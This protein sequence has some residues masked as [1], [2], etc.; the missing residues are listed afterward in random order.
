MFPSTSFAQ[1]PN[2]RRSGRFT[3]APTRHPE[4]QPKIK[5][6][7][8]LQRSVSFELPP[9]NPRQPSSVS[10][11]RSPSRSP[12]RSPHSRRTPPRSPIHVNFSP[13]QPIPPFARLSLDGMPRSQSASRS[14]TSHSSTPRTAA[15]PSTNTFTTRTHPPP[16][17]VFGNPPTPPSAIVLDHT[18][19]YNPSMPTY[20]QAHTHTVSAMPHPHTQPSA[21]PLFPPPAP[22]VHYPTTTTPP[23]HYRTINVRSIEDQVPYF[24]GNVRNQP[25]CEG[26][27]NIPL[28]LWLNALDCLF[29][30]EHITD[31]RQRIHYLIHFCDKKSGD[32]HSVLSRYLEPDQIHKTYKTVV[33]ELHDIYNDEAAETLY[34][35]VHHAFNVK[36]KP[37]SQNVPQNVTAIETAAGRMVRAYR[38]RIKYDAEND[39]R[40]VEHILLEMCMFQLM[41]LNLKP[42][43]QSELIEKQAEDTDVLSLRPKLGKLLHRAQADFGQDLLL[44][45]DENK[46]SYTSDS[47]CYA[48][49]GRGN[50]RSTDQ[51]GSGNNTNN[52]KTQPLT[53]L[54]SYNYN[55]TTRP[56]H[57]VAFCAHCQRPGHSQSECRSFNRWQQGSLTRS[58]RQ[59]SKWIQQKNTGTNQYVQGD[60]SNQR[61]NGGKYSAPNP[62]NRH[63]SRP[64]TKPQSWQ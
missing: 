28:R 18:T 54:M 4:P 44:H 51:S 40:N 37:G 5:P 47:A 17:S 2:P 39:T 11:S 20:H 45:R 53:P 29:A 1:A 6:P 13:V 21:P 32:A 61:Q 52:K 56:P 35:A 48:Y 16:H 10:S 38:N 27:A 7:K 12:N 30:K 49:S 15:P 46:I 50:M 57:Q 25:F 22:P 41:A 34:K 9:L 60:T 62:G 43:I 42:K 14:C 59:K 23:S 58:N 19:P 8:R 64:G 3:N 26:S 63:R 55:D 24:K 31:D 36:M 33:K